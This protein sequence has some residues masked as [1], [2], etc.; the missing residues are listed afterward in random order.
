[1]D[2]DAVVKGFPVLET[3]RLVLRRLGPADLAD[4]TTFFGDPAV[5]RQTTW[6]ALVRRHGVDG[7]LAHVERRRAAGEMAVW[8]IMPKGGG[9]LIGFCG[10]VE[11]SPE[12]RRA[13]I[14]YALARAEWGR[15]YAP[16]AARAVLGCA[17]DTLGF[18]RVEAYCVPENVTSIRV[19]E[20]IGMRREGVLR[21]YVAI[22]GQLRDRAVYALLRREWQAL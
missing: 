14:G 16:E 9:H 13:E 7:L 15:G 1:M 10:L 19:L 17:F 4:A 8:S 5:G 22:G 12:D 11:I 6:H 20:K 2:L 3:E 21:E 18:N